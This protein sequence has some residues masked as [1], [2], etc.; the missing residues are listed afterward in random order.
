MA[1]GVLYRHSRECADHGRCGN[2]CNS[3]DE[4]WEAWAFDRRAIVHT[5]V[6]ATRLGGR[7][8]C[9]PNRGTKIRK[10]FASHA[11]AKGWRTDA[12]KAV[13]DKKLRAPSSKTLQ[14]EV[15]EWIAGA[16]DGRILNRQKKAYKPAVLR[17]YESALRRRV[18]PELGDRRLADVDHADLL[19]LKEQLL[20]E[21]CSASTI[22]NTFVPLQAVYRRAVRNGAVP[23]NPALDLELPTPEARKRAATPAQAAKFMG[24]LGVRLGALWSVAFYAGLRRGELQALRVRNVD[25][26]AGTITVEHG[27]D[28]IEGEIDPKSAAGRRQVFLCETL[29]PYLE[30]LV[31]DGSPDAFVFGSEVSPFDARATERSAKRAIASAEKERQRQREETGETAEPVPVPVFTLHECRHTFSTFMDHAGI[32]ETRAD[33]Y[34]GHAAKGTAGRYRHLLPSQVAEDARRLDEYLSGL[35][36]GKVVEISSAAGLAAARARV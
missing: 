7:C 25:L 8:D 31:E 20:G 1:E 3:S 36:A 27:W 33:R 6:C 11:A 5:K 19:E 29:R 26:A 24:V 21:G 18:L 15:D 16:R 12:V 23:V 9:T 2:R 35:A 17:L 30:P 14:Q 22:R 13:R 4:P 10:R 28:V 34:M 32:S